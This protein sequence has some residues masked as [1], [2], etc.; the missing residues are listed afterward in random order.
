MKDKKRNAR[1]LPKIE[2]KEIHEREIVIEMKE[3]HKRYK[4]P[5]RRIIE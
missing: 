1:T 3:M 2:M 4:A 5:K